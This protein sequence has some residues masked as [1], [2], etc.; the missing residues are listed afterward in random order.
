MYIPTNRFLVLLQ[1]T[2]KLEESNRKMQ[3]E[4]EHLKK[5]LQRL[6]ISLRNHSCARNPTRSYGGDA[7]NTS[8]CGAQ[9]PPDPNALMYVNVEQ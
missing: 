9:F 1:R 7:W 5:E 4:K 6:S 2:N 3:Q 8:L